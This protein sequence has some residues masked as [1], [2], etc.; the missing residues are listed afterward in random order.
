MKIHSLPR[1]NEFKRGCTNL[2]GDLREARPSATIAEYNIS[3]VQLVIEN[4]LQTNSDSPDLVPCDF[5]LLPKIIEKLRGN[6]FTDTEKAVAAYEKAVEATSKC[7]WAKSFF[8]WLHRMQRCIDLNGH[9]FE[10]Q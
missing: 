1:F 3:A 6:W 10:K 5:Y 8:Q 2:I 4:D 9:Y 7:E